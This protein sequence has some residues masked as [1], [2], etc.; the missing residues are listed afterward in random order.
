VTSSRDIAPPPE[1]VDGRSERWREHRR[2]RREELVDAALQAVAEYGPD[3]SMEQIAAAAGTAK[4]KLYRHFADR[5]ALVEAIGARVA[6]SVLLRLANAFNPRASFRAGLR[7]GLDAYLGYVEANPDVVRFL[8]NN[9]TSSDGTSNAIVDNA[10]TIARLFVALATTDLEAA[11]IPT[12][13]AEPLAH[14]LVGAVLGA[15]DWWML[16][17]PADRMPR[18]RLVDHLAVVI[19]GAAEAALRQWDVALDAEAPGF[20]GGLT[21]LVDRP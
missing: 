3:V 11:H 18:A 19:I 20:F 13:D 15:T 10:R 4:P 16:Q 7:N 12:G 9:A 5:A 17:D 8:M 6:E 21:A 2:Q 1:R 14:T